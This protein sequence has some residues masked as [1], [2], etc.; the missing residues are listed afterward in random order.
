M[1]DTE[2]IEKKPKQKK[3]PKVVA[4]VEP[5]VPE[6]VQEKADTVAPA[7]EKQAKKKEYVMT[8]ARAEA[9]ER[10]KV[11]RA[12][13][14]LEI[15]KGKAE[16]VAILE[17]SRS[18]KLEK[19]IKKEAKKQVIVLE[20]ESSEEEEDQIIIRRKRKPTKIQAEEKVLPP[21]PPPTPPIP[22]RLRR[23]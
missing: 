12:K 15:Q 23:L 20:S 13:D 10:M 16:V 6:K 9:L 22:P 11:A 17:A 18:K 21:S 2:S 5:D 4:P 14:V 7:N 8:P 1:S 3:V 19:K